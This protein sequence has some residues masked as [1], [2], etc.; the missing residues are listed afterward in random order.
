MNPPNLFQKLAIAGVAGAVAA[1]SI[2]TAPA[3]ALK[4]GDIT[5]AGS[6]SDFIDG[7]N[8]NFTSFDDN[9][10]VS[11]GDPVGDDTTVFST[12]G[13]FADTLGTIPPIMSF[14]MPSDS[15]TLE[16]F[17]PATFPDPLPPATA[18]YRVT[19]QL[20]LDFTPKVVADNPDNVVELMYIIPENTNFLLA[21]DVGGVEFD[22]CTT[23]C[24]D[25]PFW[26]KGIDED[27][28]GIVDLE[29]TFRA[30]NVFEFEQL[31][32]V[33]QGIYAAESSKAVPEPG[34]ILGLLAIGGLGLG[35]KRKKS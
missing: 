8:P 5:W 12:T 10:S 2:A 20:V 24:L 1:T 23:T 22:L 26:K 14:D 4:G 35:M 33:S 32:G 13:H 18:Y 16:Q 15:M 29:K 28:D 11:F 7:V 3:Q 6:T 31:V 17:D 9:F 34:S 27:G 21:D 19:E 30:T 25:R